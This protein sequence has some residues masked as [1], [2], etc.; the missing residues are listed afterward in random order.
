MRVIIPDNVTSIKNGAFGFCTS[1]AGVYFLGNAP[2]V[3]YPAAFANTSTTVYFLPG[4]TGWPTP[5][6]LWPAV[7]GRPT[8]LWLPE[9]TDNGKLG[10]QAG[11]F[12]FNINWATG[13]TVVIEASTSLILTNWIPL[14]TQT[15]DSISS[16]YGDSE[17]SNYIGRVYRLH[18]Q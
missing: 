11:Q 15:L 17:W 12:G 4:A 16:Y 7:S 10:V 5:P 8:A 1:L 18:A 9:A 2:A 6:D 13:K 14:A 3:I